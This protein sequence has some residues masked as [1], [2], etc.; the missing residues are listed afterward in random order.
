MALSVGAFAVTAG[1]E[2]RDNGARLGWLID[3]AERQIH[4]YR[5][6][7]EPD[8]LDT[9]ESVSAEPELPGVT[10]DLARAGEPGL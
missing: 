7:N 5:P 8:V 3:A 2:Y 1:V 10:L 6:G 4:V 9:P